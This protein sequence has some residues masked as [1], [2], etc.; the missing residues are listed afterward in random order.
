MNITELK[1]ESRSLL[2]IIEEASG[3]NWAEFQALRT[4]F[5]RIQ[6]VSRKLPMIGEGSSRD[7]FKFGNYVLKIATGPAGV[8][9][10]KTEMSIHA[11]YPDVTTKIVKTDPKGTWLLVEYA[12][13]LNSS[14]FQNVTGISVKDWEYIFDLLGQKVDWKEKFPQYKDNKFINKMAQLF[15][16][17]GMS[18]GDLG[19]FDHYGITASGEF[20]VLDY[21]LTREVFKTHYKPVLDKQR[22]A[23]QQNDLATRALKKQAPAAPPIEK[24]SEVV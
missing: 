3:F 20:K 22:A 18:T 4:M 10:N 11:K 15:Y 8:A 5:D 9:Q 14:E 24:T 2:L 1:F 21:G 13:P 19:V 23:Q 6:Y 16:S 12:K 7:V 17:S